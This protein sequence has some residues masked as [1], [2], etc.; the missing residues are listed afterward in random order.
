MNLDAVTR[1]W[2]LDFDVSPEDLP[3]RYKYALR[4][5]TRNADAMEKGVD[6]VVAPL[7]W[8]GESRD[9]SPGLSTGTGGGASSQSLRGG[10]NNGGVGTNGPKMEFPRLTGRIR[11]F[12][13]TR[14]RGSE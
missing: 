3:V 5:A 9:S 13:T 2:W 12:R 1:T 4:G 14:S 8:I 7:G 11:R 10:Q 6:R